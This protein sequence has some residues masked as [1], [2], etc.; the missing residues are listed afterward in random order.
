MRKAL[1]LA[2]GFPQIALLEELKKR[3]Y[4]TVLADW[5]EEPVAKKHADIFYK[6]STLDVAKITEIARMEQVDFLITAC[7]DQA[8]LTVAKVS[9]ELGLPCYIDY[10]TAL[11]VT[12]KAH[13]KKIF[14][15]NGIPTAKHVIVTD[16]DEVPMDMPFPLI[17]KPVDCNSSKGVKKVQNREELQEAVQTAVAYSRTDTAVV[18]QFVQ[19][20][21]IS[22]DVYVEN[23]E[24]K[25]LC[26]S[27]N[28][29][30]ADKDKFI[31][32]RGVCPAREVAQVKEKVQKAAQKIAD[33]FALKNAPML[34]QLITDGKDIYVLEFSART[35]GGTKFLRIKS[36]TG[37]DV[38]AAVVDL[39]EGNLPHVQP[40]SEDKYLADE[41]IY[42]KPGQFDHMEGFAALK[43]QGII[44]DYYV[45]KW[46]GASFDS[47]Q[48]SGDRVGG[49]TIVADSFEN[50]KKKHQ[51]VCE[52]VKVIDM[53]GN[54]MMR[55][56]L[57]TD[58]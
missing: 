54:D 41:F 53:D 39:T 13:M 15:E 29:K 26:I 20:V 40:Q 50:L 5:N 4:V 27:N 23:G 24:A 9:E 55:H 17:V 58:L 28:D 43:E 32:F 19:G 8:L 2:G 37:F 12:N 57:L 7:T 34:I 14:V 51:I 38:I 30:I 10:A 6:E 44:H 49:F 35:G 33:A 36:F 16:A 18:E 25:V 48:S 45:F 22:V 11:A 52:N 31:I 46:K 42:C 3:G 47:V 21:E 56:D 1:V